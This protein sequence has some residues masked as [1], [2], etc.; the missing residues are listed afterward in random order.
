M[1]VPCAIDAHRADH[2]VL[3]EHHAIDVNHQQIHVIKAPLQQLFQ[4]FFACLRGP[5]NCSADNCN[6]V[7]I[8]ARP[9]TSISSS[10]ASRDCSIRSTIGSKPCPL[11]LK[12]SA[13]LS[14]FVG[15]FVVMV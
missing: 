2:V 7:S 4:C 1:L 5:A 8:V 6:P 10:T 11:R 14:A 13:S 12:N 9:A 15:P 3:A